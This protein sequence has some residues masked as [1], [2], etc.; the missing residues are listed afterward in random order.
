MDVDAGFE[1][2]LLDESGAVRRLTL[3]ELFDYSPR[4]IDDDRILFVHEHQGRP[5]LAVYRVSTSEMQVVS[6][7]PYAALDPVPAP[8]GDRVAFL[9]REGWSWTLDTVPLPAASTST[10]PS[11][12]TPSE[13]PPLPA[14]GA[15]AAP[16][17]AAAPA[18]PVE[19]ISDEPYQATDHLLRPNFH[20]PWF[21]PEVII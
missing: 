12:A 16:M 20:V 9:N 14:P 5:Q 19:V 21:Q 15:T 18:K 11:E 7:V 13:A 10:P 1:L 6:D 2:S 17:A 4:W 8:S 3:N